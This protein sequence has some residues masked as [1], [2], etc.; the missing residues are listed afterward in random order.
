MLATLGGAGRVQSNG[1]E[2]PAPEGSV[3]LFSPHAPQLYRTDPS[4]GHWEFLW[5]HFVPR[6][7]WTD[8][9]RWE[10]IDSGVSCAQLD[11]DLAERT[12]RQLASIHAHALS[13]T[14]RS[15][16]FALNGLER[17]LLELDIELGTDSSIDPRIREVLNYFSEHI[18]EPVSVPELARLANLSPSRFACIFRESTGMPP[19]Q[20]LEE[21]RMERARQLLRNTDESVKSIAIQVGFPN[22]FYF[23]R[24]FRI[25]FG[26][27]PTEY[28]ADISIPFDP[29]NVPPARFN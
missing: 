16:E 20:Y 2:S 23:T 13:G 11:P 19:L 5:V 3:A 14:P 7:H 28:R 17:L 27:S 22:P 6:P 24:R 15:R 25:F 21:L 1:P 12:Q 4:V 9:L 8:L 18:D 26:H 29:R 10:G